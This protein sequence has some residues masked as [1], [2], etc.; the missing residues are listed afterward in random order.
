MANDLDPNFDPNF[1]P[2]ERLEKELTNQ[3]IIGSL[4]KFIKG[5]WKAGQNNDDVDEGT[6]LLAYISAVHDGW[7]YWCD[8]R[9]EKYEVD[10]VTK[11]ARVKTRAELGD[12]EEGRLA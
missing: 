9:P 4:L 8:G 10:M 7:T 1:D 6:R 11:N 12:T 5:D 2:F 3:R